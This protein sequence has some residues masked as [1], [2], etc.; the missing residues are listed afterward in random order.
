MQ[1]FSTPTGWVNDWVGAPVPS[2][3]PPT[4]SELD[5]AAL[6]A[7]CGGSFSPGVEVS[8]SILIPDFYEPAEPLRLKP[9]GSGG[10]APGALRGML[11]SPWATDY[12]LGCAR[13]WPIAAP[14]QVLKGPPGSEVYERWFAGSVSTTTPAQILDWHE[15]GFV[16]R[17]DAT[18]KYVVKDCVPP[19]LPRFELEILRLLQTSI[20]RIIQIADPSPIDIIRGIRTFVSRVTAKEPEVRAA[21]DDLSR[22]A[23]ELEELDAPQLRVRLVDLK[24]QL[25]RLETAVVLVEERLKARRS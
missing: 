6:E 11:E 18:G 10:L 25:A 20:L 15:L 17:D 9:T 13:Y 22:L 19:R 7:C 5:R 3:G 14:N 4:P 16:T 2:A 1:V 23:A 12:M 21:A 8:G 24:A